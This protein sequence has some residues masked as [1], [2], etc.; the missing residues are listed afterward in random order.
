MEIDGK[1]MILMNLKVANCWKG[2]AKGLKF[3]SEVPALMGLPKEDQWYLGVDNKIY[4]AMS[5]FQNVKHVIFHA[6]KK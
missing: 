6:I 4:K 1:K 5:N 3:Y 2:F